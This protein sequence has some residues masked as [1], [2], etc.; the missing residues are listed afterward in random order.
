MRLGRDH[1]L[2][3]TEE[4]RRQVVRRT[5]LPGA[6]AELWLDWRYHRF[7]T[8]CTIR[9]FAADLDHRDHANVEL[10]IWRPQRPGVRAL[11]L[12][13]LRRQQRLDRDRRARAQSR[14]S[15]HAHRPPQPAPPDRHRAPTSPHDH[16]RSTDTHPPPLDTEPPRS[17][18]M[19]DRVPHRSGRHPDTPSANLN[20]AAS[21][22]R[23]RST[24]AAPGAL[25][26]PGNRAKRSRGSASDNK[27]VPP[28]PATN[29]T[30]DFHLPSRD[31]PPALRVNRW[32]QA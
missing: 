19:E 24:F 5:R 26:A 23:T 1:H 9:T 18:A 28:P 29:H 17:L 22:T 12:R 16:R 25:T 2:C 31:T 11:P 4:D 30:T 13:P 14:T 20:P 3:S 21:P 32:I 8:N 27:K 6:Q 15:D 10:V 7:L